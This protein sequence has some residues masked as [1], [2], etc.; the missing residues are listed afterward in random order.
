MLP[1]GRPLF[2]PYPALEYIKTPWGAQKLAVTFMTTD[3]RVGSK[4][5]GLFVRQSS[6]GG[7]F[8]ENITQATA[9]DVLFASQTPL[10]AA[11]YPIVLH[12]HDE[13]VS[14][15]PKGFGSV[16]EYEAIM[17][18]NPAWAKDMPIAAD[19]FRGARYRK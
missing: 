9:R 15:V 7:K 12:V 10:E 13:N 18:V 6:Y 3:S 4:T 19:G 5:K 1:S 8:V 16:E 17:S 14:E 11:G 2:Y